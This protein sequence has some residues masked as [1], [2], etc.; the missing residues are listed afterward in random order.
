MEVLQRRY[1]T[2]LEIR[3]VLANV[4]G[5]APG[6]RNMDLNKYSR[7]TYEFLRLPYSHS[8][9][10]LTSFTSTRSVLSA[11]LK[12]LIHCVAAGKNTE[13]VKS[14]DESTIKKILVHELCIIVIPK[15]EVVKPI[16]S[17]ESEGIQRRRRGPSDIQALSLHSPYQSSF[18]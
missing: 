13:F 16:M 10:N 15:N 3:T 6:D 18:K 12:L 2:H 9:R 4:I 1:V 8:I 5:N 7:L 14:L 17:E 11:F